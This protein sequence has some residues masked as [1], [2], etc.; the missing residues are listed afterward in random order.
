MNKRIGVWLKTNWPCW[1]RKL[2]EFWHRFEL[3]AHL[4]KMRFRLAVAGILPMRE[5]WYRTRPEDPWSGN[6]MRAQTLMEGQLPH[7][8]MESERWVNSIWDLV[9]E[10]PVAQQRYA[11]EFKWL[12][13]LQALPNSQAIAAQK[14]AYAFYQQW[15]ELDDLHSRLNRSIPVRAERLANCFCHHALL[16]GGDAALHEQTLRKFYYRELLTLADVMRRRKEKTSP[17]TLKALLYG[18]LLMPSAAFLLRPVMHNL[19]L[20]IEARFCED[21]GHRTRSPAYQLQDLTVLMEIRSTMRKRQFPVP[22]SF[23]D[24]L[25]QRLDAL[26]TMSHHDGKLAGFHS[27]SAKDVSEIINLWMTWRKPRPLPQRCLPKTGYVHLVMKESAMVMDIAC[28]EPSHPSH[29]RGTL[30]FEFS[31]NQSRFVVSCGHYDGGEALWQDIGKRTAAHST[32]CVDHFDSWELSSADEMASAALPRCNIEETEK[33]LMVM[34]QHSGYLVSDGFVHQRQLTLNDDGTTLQGVDSLL[35][36]AV[37]PHQVHESSLPIYIRFHL[38]PEV[39]MEKITP[40]GVY[41]KLPNK[42]YW[43]FHITEPA[44]MVPLVEESIFFEVGGKKVK[45]L[46]LVISAQWQADREM[47]FAWCF[48]KEAIM[49]EPG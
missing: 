38:H 8:N 28:R 19:K 2:I 11:Y 12:R 46:Q 36:Q 47:Q 37:T 13:D 10:L 1:Q 25:Q 16:V 23:D 20:A 35:P 7:E 39:M 32:L 15:G 27:S 31:R 45:T 18:A 22:G 29:S 6:V 9:V 21:G 43:R 30:A 24:L 26:A 48:S 4:V 34:A 5:E 44:S 14:T 40:Q 49:D 3:L 33:S 41:M 42:E 17:S